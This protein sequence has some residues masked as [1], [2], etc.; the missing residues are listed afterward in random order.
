[1]STRGRKAEPEE[2]EGGIVELPAAPAHFD[3]EMAREWTAILADLTERKLLT[4]TMLGSVE[5]Y[6]LAR[7]NVRKAQKAI[8]EHGVLVSGA[9]GALKPNPASGLLWRS[10]AIVARMAA[11]LGLT[12]ASRA[13]TSQKPEEKE[14]DLFSLMD[15]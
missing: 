12:P 14:D 8:E 10:Q 1:M 7:I 9:E 11:E 4:E 3:D 5:M 6:V 15:I 13:K 2:I